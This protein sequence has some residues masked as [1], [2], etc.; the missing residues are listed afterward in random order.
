MQCP[1]SEACFRKPLS[2]SAQDGAVAVMTALGL[3]VILGLA[4]LAVDLGY[5][6]VV[7]CELQRAADAGAMA[8]ARALFFPERAAPP[9]CG[10]AMT[11]G[12]EIA[13]LNLV[14]GGDPEVASIQT[15]VWNWSASW[16]T[17]S[18]A[19]QPFTNA[20]ALT[21]RQENVSLFL[22]NLTGIGPVSLRAS[23]IA[24]MDWVKELKPGII[25][26]PV[27]VGQKWAVGGADQQVKIYF[28]DEEQDRGGWYAIPPDNVES[29]YL[30]RMIASPLA[31]PLSQGQSIRVS[32]GLHQAA[33][34]D[35]AAYLNRDVWIPVVNS[36]TFNGT[37]T[38]EGF[39][40]LRIQNIGQDA[41]PGEEGKPGGK[42]FL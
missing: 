30:R 31:A 42:K 37:F 14:D 41:G 19:T 33:L 11:K 24:V 7:K 15:G 1:G 38:I 8:G 23:S 36:D 21:T 2:G 18:C 32:T 4:G 6:Y 27:T 35:L 12:Q 29:D 5:L 40:A 10:A 34:N 28:N 13:G 25:A 39:A 22:M 9:Q 16:F 26:I 20:L 3:M 17:P